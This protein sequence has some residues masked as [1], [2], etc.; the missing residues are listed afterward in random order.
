MIPYKIKDNNIFVFLQK[1]EKDRKISPGCLAFFGGKIEEGE[2]PEEGMK[3][4]IQEELC[5][6]P[7]GYEFLGK[8]DFSEWI[9]NVYILP[10]DDNFESKIR[11]MEGEYG[12]FF[13]KAEAFSE[14]TMIEDNKI[15]LKDLFALLQN[16][17]AH[18]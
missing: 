16:N 7:Q 14:P 6:L 3:R 17:I 9:S 11:I 10:V 18:A 5:F 1:R 8:Y 2:S 13:S 4:E 12:K 15:I